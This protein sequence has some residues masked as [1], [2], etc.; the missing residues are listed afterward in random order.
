MALRH[1]LKN[2]SIVDGYFYF[3]VSKLDISLPLQKAAGRTER[4]KTASGNRVNDK[5]IHIFREIGQKLK[6]KVIRYA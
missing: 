4:D 3:R 5:I 6:E 2:D 1:N